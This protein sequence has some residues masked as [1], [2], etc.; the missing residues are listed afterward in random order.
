MKARKL[1]LTAGVVVALA[2]PASAGAMIQSDGGSLH[3]QA[4]TL[5]E[6]KG[7]T[8]HRTKA[9]GSDTAIRVGEYN[10][11]AYV[12]GGASQKVA[13]AITRAGKKLA[14]PA[15]PALPRPKMIVEPP[16]PYGSGGTGVNDC[17]VSNVCTPEELCS[18]YGEGCLLLEHPT[19]ALEASAEI[20]PVDASTVDGT[21]AADSTD[22]ASADTSGQDSGAESGADAT[23]P[24][25]LDQDC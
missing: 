14:K 8:G 24:S 2:G 17:Q 22:T 18:I 20:P 6:V 5:H 3:P 1:I 11:Y 7:K 12:P 4:G 9:K 16:L 13:K 19:P 10:A 23:D 21:S 15:V 25:L